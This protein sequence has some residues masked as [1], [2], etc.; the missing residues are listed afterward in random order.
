MTTRDTEQFAM[1]LA[2]KLNI[3]TKRVIDAMKEIVREDVIK[4]AKNEPEGKK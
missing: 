2:D 4:V 1:R 3:D